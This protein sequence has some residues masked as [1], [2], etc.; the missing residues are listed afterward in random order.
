MGI[1][2]RFQDIVNANLTSLLDRAED[3]KKMIRQMIQEMEDTLIEVRSTS[4]K[5]IADKK[6]L[7]RRIQMLQ[8]EANDWLNKTELAISKGREDL[9]KGA[10]IEKRR[11]EEAVE[12]G[13]NELTFLS[14]Q[15]NVLNDE[16]SQ[17]QEK[18]ASAKGKQKELL[19]REQTGKSRL[20][21]R[22]KTNRETLNRAFEKFEQYE[23]RL[24]DLE[25]QVESYDMGKTHK[26]NLADEI[27]D[28]AA[29]DDIERELDA[30]K[31]KINSK[32]E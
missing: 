6:E 11:A 2:S 7:E 28:L 20:E 21:I 9:A 27:N 14:E 22:K 1:F 31:S 30:I 15:L 3:P 24:D 29:A 19:L 12:A 18:L 26:T 8:D 23:R 13:D 16:I 4:A 32:A 10:L 17:L 25:G 5:I